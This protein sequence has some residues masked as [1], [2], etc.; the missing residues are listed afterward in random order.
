MQTTNSHSDALVFF[1]ATGDLAYKKIFPSLQA[2]VKRG[3]LDMP[4]IGVAKA[5]WNIE[6]FRARARDSV[7]KH[8]AFDRAAFDKLCRLLH[9]VDGDYK[10]PATFQA[11]RKELGARSR[12]AYYLAIPP[13]L[14]ALVVEELGK[15]CC[16]RDA[17]VILEK[18]FGTDW[19][20]ARKLNE[21]LLAT[22]PESSIFRI[23]HYLGK[24][25]VRNMVFFRF[26]NSF[27]EPFWNRN[28]VE[29]VQITMAE[30]FGVQGRG[31]FYDQTGTIRDVVQNHLFQ[32][33]ANLAMEPPV[34]TDSES[35]RDEKVKVLKAI[36]P[37]TESDVVRGQF[38]GYKSEKGVA[39][40][41][42]TE[43]Y[44]ALQL[45]VDSWRWQGVP[46]YIRAGK[47]LPV[48]S[49]EVLV[50]LRLPPEIYSR[51]TLARNHI[52]F[53]INP[54]V[55]IAMGV[56]ALAPGEDL[57]TQV[58]EMVASRQPCP[59]EMDAYEKVLGDAI[60]GD[61]TLFARQDYVEEAWRIVD[62]VLKAN[63]PV[64]EYD[65]GTWGPEETAQRIAPAEGWNNPVLAAEPEVRTELSA[66][67]T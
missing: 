15:L 31:A 8:G 13:A 63:T 1:G 28:Y 52:R 5:G 32:V 29:S 7:E 35:I 56:M 11:I 14:F 26:A 45:G 39:P 33:L 10:D 34:R 36:K 6:Q 3:N 12:P 64:Y 41:S 51:N 19:A 42:R 30:D 47:C 16:V 37:L 25:P 53:R 60:T 4:V 50:R 46:F 22:F 54:E 40:K 18:P 20:S 44:V 62:T 43:T 48:T 59:E 58:V 67:G 21:V 27:L 38:R 17:R 24:K 55:A 49:T 61:A 66:V 65:P 2:M 57:R 9:Y 23:D